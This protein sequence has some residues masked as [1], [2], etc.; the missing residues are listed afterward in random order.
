MIRR[1]VSAVV[2][3]RDSFTG[4]ILP[5]GGVCL[6]DGAPLRRPIWKADGY[7]VLED[8][9][10]GPHELQVRRPGFGP[11]RA[12]LQAGDGLWEE[13]IDLA[14]GEGYR[15]PPDTAQLTV[16]FQGA[17]AP[18]DGEQIWLGQGGPVTLKLAQNKTDAPQLRVRLFAQGPESALPVPGRYLIADPKAP[19]LV[20][21]RSLREGE[22]MLDQPMARPHPRGVEWV[23]VH[24]CTASGRAVT[25]QLCR[26][27][28]VWLFYRGA[29]AQTQ[30]HS[31][32][33]EFVWK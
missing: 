16:R 30:V 15:F 14:P 22:G 23:C 10:P 20:T 9:A 24:P 32:P 28:T 1:H 2:R 21:L 25:V 5:G 17:G 33:Q 19:E 8:L 3:L 4:R 26:A 31:G 12:L 27:G 6:L 18:A 13:T 7:L 11:G 29:L